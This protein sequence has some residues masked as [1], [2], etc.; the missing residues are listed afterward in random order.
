MDHVHFPSYQPEKRVTP[1]K[2]EHNMHEQLIGAVLFGYMH[3]LVPE[4]FVPGIRVQINVPVPENIAEKRKWCAFRLRLHKVDMVYS[5]KGITSRHTAQPYK[6]M[7]QHYQQGKRCYNIYRYGRLL[8]AD[9]K[10]PA[11]AYFM[12]IL[13]AGSYHVQ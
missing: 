13:I 6:G 12:H 2:D 11:A 1:E 8:T 7:K 3:H 9:M 5:L 10:A 4:Y